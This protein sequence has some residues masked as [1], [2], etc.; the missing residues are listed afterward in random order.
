MRTGHIDWEKLKNAPFEQPY[1]EEDCWL[2]RGKPDPT[3]Q[4][5]EFY[6]FYVGE[7]RLGDED[8]KEALLRYYNSVQKSR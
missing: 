2:M 4:D 5:K 3:N 1:L 6:Y 7:G 8:G